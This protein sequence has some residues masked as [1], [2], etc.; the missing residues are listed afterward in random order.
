M[1]VRT[2]CLWCVCVCVSW[3]TA[4]H[5]VVDLYTDYE[6]ATVRQY[7]RLTKQ[8]KPDMQQ[9]IREKEKLYVMLCLIAL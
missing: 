9:Y 1:V 6:Q 8:H 2:V 4:I 5:K 7:Q 3:Y